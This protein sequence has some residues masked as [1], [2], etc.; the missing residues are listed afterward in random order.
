MPGIAV[1]ITGDAS[2]FKREL[3]SATN[4]TNKANSGMAK[5]QKAALVAGAALAGGLVVG[6]KASVGA[7]KEAEVSQQRMK[8]QLDALNISYEDHAEQIDKVIQSTSK[9]AALDDEDLQDAFTQ[10][11]R[12]T[13]DVNAALKDTQ[14]AA[15]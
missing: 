15:D 9:L 11:V 3:Q 4:A 6:L 7:A 5:M 8:T 2:Q 13:G 10:L 14:L 1:E 12:T